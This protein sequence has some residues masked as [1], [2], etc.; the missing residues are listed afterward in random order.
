MTCDR[1]GRGCGVLLYRN[2][3][4]NVSM[5]T[6][7]RT[8][9]V[10]LQFKVTLDPRSI[11]G[12]VEKGFFMIGPTDIVFLE[13]QPLLLNRWWRKHGRYACRG[14]C[15]DSIGGDGVTYDLQ[16]GV[17]LTPQ[18]LLQLFHNLSPVLGINPEIGRE[19]SVPCR[20][21]RFL[22]E[23]DSRFEVFP[24]SLARMAQAP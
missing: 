18:P 22:L 5:R 13:K 15:G 9:L 24:P 21:R 17:D 16:D 19:M 10:V 23:L 8:L 2:E 11:A 6:I 7:P 1:S 20:V 12:V 4:L 14:F 3:I